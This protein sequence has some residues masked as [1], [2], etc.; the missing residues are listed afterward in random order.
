[1]NRLYLVKLADNYVTGVSNSCIK[2]SE[3]FEKS[4]VFKDE[5]EA[6]SI[7]NALGARVITFV[8]ED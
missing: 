1:M 4:K 8:L 7:A 3:D 2:L 6:E 5:I